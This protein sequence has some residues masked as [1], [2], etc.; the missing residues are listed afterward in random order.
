MFQKFQNYKIASYLNRQNIEYFMDQSNPDFSI[1]YNFSMDLDRRD[2]IFCSQVPYE[3]FL[4]QGI[5]LPLY[6]SLLKTA[7]EN[8]L[9]RLLNIKVDSTFAP[10]DI[11]LD[12]RFE[13][14]AEWRDLRKLQDIRYRDAILVSFFRWMK[15][16]NYKFHPRWYVVAGSNVALLARQLDLPYITQIMSKNMDAQ[17]TAAV[18]TL[19]SL[20]N[21]M[22]E[23]IKKSEAQVS[24]HQDGLPLTMKQMTAVLDKY[25]IEDREKHR[26]F[27]DSDFHDLFRP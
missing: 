12:T 25:R 11:E 4:S 14:I 16:Y 15:D 2:S 10:G 1:P 8:D 21:K 3:G 9:I 5:K 23:R 19:E 20:G 17:T 22:V 18:V 6:K 27:K 7:Q 26:L 24:P 13:F